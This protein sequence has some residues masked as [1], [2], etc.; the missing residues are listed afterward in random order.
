MSAGPLLRLSHKVPPVHVHPPPP[1]QGQRFPPHT[2]GGGL[3]PNDGS[4]ST[5]QEGGGGGR[6]P[7]NSSPEF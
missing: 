1:P 3:S 7:H 5:P 6:T 4:P 2:P